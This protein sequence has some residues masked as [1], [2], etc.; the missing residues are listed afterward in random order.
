MQKVTMYES[1]LL[2]YESHRFDDS[3]YWERRVDIGNATV[4]YRWRATGDFSMVKAELDARTAIL[5]RRLAAYL[6]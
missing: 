5:S 1:E 6:K 4:W 3:K 2:N